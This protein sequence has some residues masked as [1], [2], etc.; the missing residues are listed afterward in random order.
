MMAVR[1][2][3]TRWG[4]VSQLLHWLIVALIAV[5]V[6]LGL[7]GAMLPVGIDKLATLARHKSIGITI[8]AL[9][10]V[11]ITWR[12][13]NPTPALPA[14]LRPFERRLARGTHAA[15][16]ALLF[17][18]PLTGWSM[19]S[20]RGF[21]VSWF[22]LFQLPNLVGQNQRLY[23]ALLETHQLL[24]IA[25]GVVVALHI[26]AALKHHFVLKDDTLRRML[27]CGR[28]TPYS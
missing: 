7:L 5:Q 19:S 17:A 22:N 14:D 23:R 2:S 6:T 1:N 25:L 4:A 10:V 24:A 18:L 15:L 28:A 12:W 26:A 13:I 8:L 3:S 27:P 21:T 11:R 16:Y 20:A 9:A